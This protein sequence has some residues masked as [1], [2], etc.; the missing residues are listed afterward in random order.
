[1]IGAHIFNES[2]FLSFLS[3]QYHHP[4]LYHPDLA[5]TA[6]SIALSILL[7]LGVVSGEKNQEDTGNY[8]LVKREKNGEEK[9]DGVIGRQHFS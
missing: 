7:Y 8:F 3:I 1:M 4:L 6:I 9:L 5:N 2:N